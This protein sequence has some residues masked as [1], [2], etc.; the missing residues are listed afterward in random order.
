MNRAHSDEPLP[1]CPDRALP[2]LRNL[3]IAA[4]ALLLAPGCSRSNGAKHKSPGPVV[5]Y[6]FVNGGF[7]SG[8]TSGWTIT[9][10]INPSIA[11]FPPAQLSDLNLQPGGAAETSA[12]YGA[13]TL[14]QVPWGLSA[15]ESL[16]FPRYG[17]YA[18]QEN[19]NSSSLYGNSRNANLISQTMTTA[20]ADVDP[21]DG[22]IHIRFALA[23][24][25]Q[26]PGH[27]ANQQP[28]FFV[29]LL[30]NTQGTSLFSTFNFANQPGVPW[31]STPNGS[32]EYT[33]W[34][35]FDV[36]P[37]GAGIAIGDSITLNAVASGCAAGG[38]FGVVYL[39]SFGSFIPGITASAS[40]PSAANAGDNITYTFLV[41]NGGGAAETNVTVE[42]NLPAN[43]TFVS[44]NAPGATC[45]APAV[46]SAGKVSCNV[47]TLN[48][49]ASTT[50][51]VTVQ[52]DPSLVAGSV[53][54]N[55]NYDVYG[56]ATAPLIGPLVRTTVT[57]GVV[58]A[59]LA[60]SNSDGVAAVGWGAAV[61][62]TIV[63]SN[64]GPNDV[65]GASITDSFPGQLTGVSWTCAGSGT[66]TDA[67]GLGDLN[68]TADLPAGTSVTY[69]VSAIVV[70]GAGTGQITSS[71]SIAAPIGV[72]DSDTS[73]NTA[74]DS[75]GV[76]TLRTLTLT[77]SGNGSGTVVSSPAA[78]AC[79]TS[80]TGS[81]GQ[82][83]DGTQVSLTATA[84]NGAT[85]NGWTGPCNDATNPCT[86]T[87]SGDLTLDASFSV[88]VYTI[89]WSAPGGN[90]SLVC[91]ATVAQGQTA[92]CTVTP[93]PGYV[94]DTLTRDGNDD[95]ASVSG[96]LYSVANVCASF[97]LVVSFK[98]DLGSGC[99]DAS[100]CHAG[101]CVDG[102]CCNVACD[103]QCQACD[104]A[105]S[106]GT[107]SP[108]AGAPH[109]VRT[110]C[111]GDGSACNAACDGVTP[112]SCTFPDVTT[113]CRAASCASGVATAAAYCDGAGSCPAAQTTMCGYFA[114]GASE[115]IVE[116]GSDGE[117][118]TDA[119]YCAG[120]TCVA[121]NDIGNACTG[122]RECGTGHCVDGVCCNSACDGQCEACDLPSQ[123]GVCSAVL[124]APHGLRSACASDGSLCGGACDGTRVDACAFPG[125]SVQCGDASCA[126]GSATAPAT[127]NGAGACASASSQS[128]GRYGCDT[129]ACKSSCAGDSDCANGSV[130]KDGLCV[131]P[132][133]LGDAC[134]RDGACGSGHCVDGVCCDTACTGQ[135]QTC[136]VT[137]HAGTCTAAKGTPVGARPACAGAGSACGATCDGVTGSSCTFAGTGTVCQ[138]QACSNSTATTASLC[139]GAGACVAGNQQSCAWGCDSDLCAAE[140]IAQNPGT[141]T[142]PTTP[143]QPQKGVQ[144]NQI[145]SVGC[146]MGG[147]D[148]GS[149]SALLLI[150]VAL[151]FVSRR[152]ARA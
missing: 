9:P 111:A 2:I 148:R 27:P 16:R 38:H 19:I 65:I 95:Y 151:F 11:V 92:T 24:V 147:A 140:P 52:I 63:A 120:G 51:Q 69:T 114:C 39:D 46:G 149:P 130:C 70:G 47:G 129:S 81:S 4:L 82:Y 84:G 128:C 110:A 122:D 105:G 109:G 3:L 146:S 22:K 102:V 150:A 113:Q 1:R 35:L 152:R 77:K 58:Y 106:V 138:P 126:S 23:P 30:N 141:P 14:S 133:A 33:D 5:P 90:G 123:P 15:A 40:A 10:Y 55:G 75:D 17:S 8:D 60:I 98:K 61:T 78:I 37:G 115:C 28:Y 42:E 87:I 68:T 101:F 48:P 50:F 143:D 137:G 112:G 99:G 53:I 136:N 93:D 72:T 88:P 118:V 71:V 79:D 41:S 6:T 86:F 13:T 43:T 74:V 57:S 107:C 62:Y 59:D 73:N 85:F 134:T 18:L 76:G 32:V 97:S 29:E 7:E 64:N 91:P 127:C 108:V 117:C 26:N 96:N 45:T 34:Q 121:K 94:L 83:V 142:T 139:D 132:S 49:S 103:G 104:V 125:G 12:Q 131:G 25:L 66:C 21:A 56:D 67:S 135:C 54:N 124:G 20:A 44:V 80:C 145:P 144:T 119:A 31:K 36:A 100:E 89:S 116:C